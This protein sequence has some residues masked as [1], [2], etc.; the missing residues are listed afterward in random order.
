MRKRFQVR[1]IIEFKAGTALGSEWEY[2]GARKKVWMSTQNEKQVLT[3]QSHLCAYRISR[4]SDFQK[5]HRLSG[6]AQW[7][8]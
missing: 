4:S 7:L 5:N 8:G 6:P 1:G 3:G 2:L